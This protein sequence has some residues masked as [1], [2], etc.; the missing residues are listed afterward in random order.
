MDFIK[1]M[2]GTTSFVAGIL[3]VLLLIVSVFGGYAFGAGTLTGNE[4]VSVDEFEDLEDENENLREQVFALQAVNADLRKEKHESVSNPQPVLV[5]N[6]RCDRYRDDIDDIE[7]DL[8]DIED[9]IDDKR[10]E[11]SEAR[12]NGEDTTELEEEL[13]ELKEEREELE[14]DL[15]DAEDDL[16][17]Y[18]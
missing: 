12:Q 6:F 11:I 2:S 4:K 18:C 7:D 17:R 15:D 16:R 9:D 5:E 3:L 8:E 10:D 13:A 14:D 1:I